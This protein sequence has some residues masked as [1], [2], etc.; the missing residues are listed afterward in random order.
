MVERL[1]ARHIYISRRNSIFSG[2]QKNTW[3]ITI[4]KSGFKDSAKLRKQNLSF[5]EVHY[6]SKSQSIQ[7]LQR[8]R[9]HWY[10]SAE[11]VRRSKHSGV[12]LADVQKK[13]AETI[14]CHRHKISLC[15]WAEPVAQTRLVKYFSNAYDIR[16]R[17]HVRKQVYRITINLPEKQTI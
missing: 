13:I 8:S 3:R 16:G 12:L 15:E 6:G 17:I 2:G 5:I 9:L 10:W 14:L 4:V 1:L 11:S 7:W